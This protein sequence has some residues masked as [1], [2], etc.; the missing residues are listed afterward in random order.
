MAPSG[1]YEHLFVMEKRKR[2]EPR[3]L[4]CPNYGHEEEE[5]RG[6]KANREKEKGEKEKRRKGEKETRRKGETEKKRKGVMRV[7]V[8][9]AWPAREG[10]YTT[11]SCTL[12]TVALAGRP[13]NNNVP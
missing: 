5:T 4:L 9:I 1:C 6:E 3:T 7:G 2:L 8:T 12:R 10:A 11:R 13:S